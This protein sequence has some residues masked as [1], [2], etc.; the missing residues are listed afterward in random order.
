SRR[1][2]RNVGGLGPLYRSTFQ[3]WISALL[4]SALLPCLFLV[5]NDVMDAAPTCHERERERV[6]Q[7]CKY[8]CAKSRANRVR[9]QQRFQ[10]C[11]QSTPELGVKNCQ[12]KE[13]AEL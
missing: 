2:G 13:R 11:D 7:S 1:D 12:F 10:Y 5:M 4:P 3:P 8:D 6:R 9:P